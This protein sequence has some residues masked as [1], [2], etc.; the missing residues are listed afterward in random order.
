VQDEEDGGEGPLRARLQRT[1]RDTYRRPASGARSNRE[2][3]DIAATRRILGGNSRL[4]AA[5]RRT[6]LG[7]VGL[8]VVIVLLGRMARLAESA[9]AELAATE[10]DAPSVLAPPAYTAAEREAI[11][12][13]I[14]EKTLVG[15]YVATGLDESGANGTYVKRGVFNKRPC[16]ENE[17]GWWLY[18]TWTLN[19]IWSISPVKTPDP[20]GQPGAYTHIG[21]ATGVFLRAGQRPSAEMFPMPNVTA[22]E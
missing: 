2:A 9:Q 13:A 3:V 4:R 11:L 6:V 16:Y 22:R 1:H 19:D 8:A 21:G 18:C 5:V 20:P 10:G 7:A 15:S 12:T 14:S 17:Q